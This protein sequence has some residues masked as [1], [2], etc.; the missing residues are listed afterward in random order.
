MHK[1]RAYRPSP[2]PF[3]GLIK[4]GVCYCKT[5]RESQESHVMHVVRARAPAVSH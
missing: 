4:L 1:I 3:S 2:V 5:H